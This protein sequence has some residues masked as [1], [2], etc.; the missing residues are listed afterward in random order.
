M[1]A[2]RRKFT[3]VYSVFSNSTTLKDQAT[4]HSH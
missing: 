4:C 2:K 1:K 3:A